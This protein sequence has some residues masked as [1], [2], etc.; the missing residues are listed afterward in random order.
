VTNQKPRRMDGGGI[1]LNPVSVVHVRKYFTNF[2]VWWMTW[3]ILGFKTI[4]L[5]SSATPIVMLDNT[6]NVIFIIHY[7]Q[8]HKFDNCVEEYFFKL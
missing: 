8:G 7:I 2:V 1:L 3:S 6:Q 5:V 4:D